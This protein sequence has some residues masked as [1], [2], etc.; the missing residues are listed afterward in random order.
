[1]RR[2]TR[3]GLAIIAA[4][5]VAAGAYTAFWFVVAGRIESGLAD[6][7]QSARAD[8]LD[9]SWQKIRVGG[10]PA[11]IL[12]DLDSVV[13]HDGA[14]TP[15]PEFHVAVLSGVA[16]PWNF[17]DWRL[18]MPEGFTADLAAAGGRAPARLVAKTADGLVSIEPA[19]GWKLQLTLR[20]TT[21]AA[22]VAIRIGLAHT[23]V[24]VPPRPAHGQGE[25]VMT[26]AVD[27]GEIGLPVPIEPLG[28][29]LDELTFAVTAKGALPSGNLTEAVTAWRDAGGSIEIDNLRVKWGAL[30]ATAAGTLALDQDLQPIGRLSGAIGGYDE[31]LAALVQNG[32][33]RA[34][35]AG[36][37]RIA[38]TLLAKTGPDGTPEIRTGF[39]IQ[40]GQMFLGPAKLG[41]VPRLTWE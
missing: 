7:A 29:M 33:I 38:L 31:I 32:Q 37:A 26:L 12:V 3:L 36:L 28:N 25:P 34:A 35:D 6:W 13:L 40:G 14:R 4:L 19:G 2:P 11:A 23:T 8:K 16:R 41:K 5:L 9:V 17:A 24:T 10:Y 1:M 39:T 20:D 15:A 30:S 27:A 22:G 21:V 18:W